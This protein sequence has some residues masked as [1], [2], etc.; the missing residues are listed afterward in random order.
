MGLRRDYPNSSPNSAIKP[1]K[2]CKCAVVFSTVLSDPFIFETL[3]SIIPLLD[4][5]FTLNF[6][7]MDF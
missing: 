4:E 5:L 6:N 2:Q 3:W 1:C 7:A